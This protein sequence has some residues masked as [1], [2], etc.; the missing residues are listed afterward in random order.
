MNTNART[1]YAHFQ[2][3]QIT[4]RAP[5]AVPQ[6]AWA[7][8]AG[9]VESAKGMCFFLEHCCGPV[10][11]GLGNYSFLPLSTGSAPDPHALA[12]IAP[13]ALSPGDVLLFE[14]TGARTALHAL[15]A[16]RPVA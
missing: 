6:R 12:P 10:P 14:V 9:V 11:A 16:V 13:E 1:H 7:R 3:T 2:T 8:V 5:E 15:R 4:V